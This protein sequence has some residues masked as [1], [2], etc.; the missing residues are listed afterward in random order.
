[1]YQKR[2]H[3][4]T[5]LII[6]GIGIGLW[7]II[8]CLIHFALRPES[9]EQKVQ[10]RVLR[11][12]K[13]MQNII[14]QGLN[15]EDIEKSETGLFVFSNDSLTYWNNNELHPKLIKRR[16]MLGKDTICSVP[17]GDYYFKSC[18]IGNS[19][20]YLFKLINTHYRIENQYFNNGFKPFSKW[21]D[22]PMRFR[23][24]EGSFDI[25]NHEGKLL[26]K[27]QFLDKPKLRKPYLF[28][29][30]PLATLVVI[31]LLLAFSAR[32]KPKSKE[33]KRKH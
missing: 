24:N 8:G 10:N 7:L 16:I 25:L 22:A 2:K 3:R 12:D 20:Y 17:S 6:A 11:M 21:I 15:K 32:R 1:M 4:S 14:N 18:Q 28:W 23:P 26:A 5:G 30:I 29:H 27:G 19:T 31:G 9:L 33:K 13:E